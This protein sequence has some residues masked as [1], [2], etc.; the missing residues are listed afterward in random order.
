MYLGKAMLTHQDKNALMVPST[1]PD[2]YIL[3]L[4]YPWDHL[5]VV[6]DPAHYA[7]KT[8]TEFLVLLNLAHK[9]YKD[10]SGRVKDAS[11]SKLL[12]KTR[13]PNFQHSVASNHQALTYVDTTCAR[14]FKLM[15]DHVNSM[16]SKPVRQKK[17]FSTCVQI[18]VVTS[19]TMFVTIWANSTIRR[20]TLQRM[21]LSNA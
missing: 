15:G 9:Y 7:E 8:F 20:A 19:A 10:Q 12:V 14:C 2:H 1:L 18:F 13:W 6:L 16:G 5:V 3:F 4:V 21:T 17:P 11:K